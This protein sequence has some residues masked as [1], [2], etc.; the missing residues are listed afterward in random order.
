MIKRL[1]KADQFRVKEI[2][3]TIWE[4]DDYIPRVFEKW[5]HDP[6]CYFM[7]LWKG[8][9]LI[10][11]DNLRLF[12][13]K[14]GWMEGMRIDPAFQGRGYGKEL[15]GEMLKLAERLGL[16]K[17]YFAT[18]FDNTASIKMNEAFGFKRIAVFTNLEREI[19]ESTSCSINLLESDEIPEIDDHISEDWM[20]IP[21]EVLNKRRF[22]NNPVKL[23]D[24]ANWAIVS[25]NSKSKGCLDINYIEVAD[26]DSLEYFLKELACYAQAKGFV[27]IHAMASE[28]CDLGPF[29]SNGFRP[30]ERIEDVFLYYADVSSLRV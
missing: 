3:E 11:V 19:C 27:R 23:L 6:S 4:G 29:L 20:F 10:G 7:G 2:V 15:G 5:V 25:K 13:R 18:Y 30:F 8:G 12:S 17:L 16:E 21:K 28:L 26:K 14:V 24:G 22:L 1:E 9:R